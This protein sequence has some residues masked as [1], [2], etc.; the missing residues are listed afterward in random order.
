MM[1]KEGLFRCW[2]TDERLTATVN[3]W[4]DV[5]D[6]LETDAFVWLD[7]R[8]GDSGGQDMAAQSGVLSEL[9]AGYFFA[10]EQGHRLLHSSDGVLLFLMEPADTREGFS[11]LR[12]W[13]A[14]HRMITWGPEGSSAADALWYRLQQEGWTRSAPV[15][16]GLLEETSHRLS[17]M[18]LQ[19]ENRVDDLESSLLNA[20][21]GFQEV[22]IGRLSDLRREIIE[23]RRNC[24]PLAAVFTELE[25]T[26][27][28]GLDQESGNMHLGAL[29][30]RSALLLSGLRDLWDRVLVVQEELNHRTTERTGRI[31][32]SLS[33]V[34]SIFL[35][36]TFLTGLFGINV[37]GIPGSRSPAGFGLFVLAMLVLG[38]V[39]YLMF[40][41]AHWL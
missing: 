8:I 16:R 17:G 7:L 39:E 11:P 36:L 37:G 23:L 33:I 26:D 6:V 13:L 3:R 29:S 35:P 34:G 10:P 22:S 12:I 1:S 40:R 19:L 28:P 41:R 18:V 25:D 2:T 27:I 5:R 38:L 15:I 31:I 32:Y 30:K 21:T 20:A 24:T 9:V 14:P 4:Q